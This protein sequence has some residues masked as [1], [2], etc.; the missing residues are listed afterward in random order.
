[1]L[2]KVGVLKFGLGD[3]YG[4]TVIRD[5]Q[6]WREVENNQL[7]VKEKDLRGRFLCYID[8]DQIPLWISLC[9]AK[10]TC[11]TH[12]TTT[13]SYFTTKLRRQGRAIVIELA[14]CDCDYL[15]IYRC[16]TKV[17][18]VEVNLSMKRKI[19]DA[20]SKL[21]EKMT[22]A[23][24]DHNIDAILKQ[25]HQK[26]VLDTKRITKS[27]QI[28]EKRLQF[29]ETLSK[30]ILGGLRLRGVP[31]SQSGFQK[32]YRMTF[33]AAEFTHRNELQQ[34]TRTNALDITFEALQSTVETLLELF[35]K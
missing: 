27:M 16:E 13:T 24:K 21:E 28:S 15:I 4:Q 17:E 12:S 14:P 18:C 26:H 11:L 2:S 8:L 6:L 33:S 23:T 25:S 20:I 29:N 7:Q 9:S 19:D 3:K 35:C 32:L 22:Q 30:L 5:V 34:L 10:S 1:M 31:N